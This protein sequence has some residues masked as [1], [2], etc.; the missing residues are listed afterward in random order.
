MDDPLRNRPRDLLVAGHINVDE[1]LRVD[2]FPAADRTVPVVAHRAELGGT[3]TTIA[4]TAS[5]YGVATGLVARLGPG[6]PPEFLARLRAGQVDLRGIETITGRT[7]PTCYIMEDRGGGQRTLIDQGAMSDAPPHRFRVG[8]WISEYAWVHLTTGPPV[9]LLELQARAHR[10]GL[11]VAADPGQETHYRWAAG[12][13][14][15][16][17]RGAEIFWGNRSE[18]ERACGLLQ[19]AGPSGLLALV[20]MVVRTEGVRGAT[21]FTPVGAVHVGARRPRRVRSVV[22]AGDAF[23]GGFY[24]AWF[25]GQR[26]RE[27]LTAGTRAAARWMEGAR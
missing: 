14:R 23:R 13:L 2:E 15:R 11:H 7:T 9:A 17:V 27:C 1:F 20:P 3:A 12:R 22:G 10:A 24:A 19:V 6:F 8:A 16:L 18:I 4:L 5:R 25:S 26:L 21:A